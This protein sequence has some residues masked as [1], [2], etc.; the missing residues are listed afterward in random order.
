MALSLF[1]LPD[2][3]LTLVA[4]YEDGSAIV[5]H[6][7]ELLGWVVKYRAQ[8]HTQPV[9]SLDVAPTRNFFLT[10]SADAII[11]KHPIPGQGVS[12]PDVEEDEKQKPQSPPRQGP[13]FSALSAA[14]SGQAQSGS[15]PQQPRPTQAHASRIEPLT[16]TH[17]RHAGQ[18]GLRIRSDGR[19]FAT[20]GWDSMVRVYSARTLKEVAALR[21]HREGCYATAFSDFSVPGSASLESPVEVT[22]EEPREPA[23]AGRDTSSALMQVPSLGLKLR[24]KRANEAKDAHWLAAGGKDGRVSLWNVF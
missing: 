2:G 15:S 19:I 23:E 18:Q 17:T 11:T 1:H 10:S 20:A 9:L 8:S 21:W 13:G 22:G 12:P 5:A 24:D 7:E 4:G 16:T 14:L 3:P 6:F